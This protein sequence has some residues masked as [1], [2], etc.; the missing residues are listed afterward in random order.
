MLKQSFD[1]GKY[2]VI[3]EDKGAMKALRY[4]EEWRDLTGDGMVLSMLFEVDKL[5]TA[6]EIIAGKLPCVD[7]CMGNVDIAIAALKEN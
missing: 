7:N 6:L 5:R 4:G 1:N 2:T 3:F